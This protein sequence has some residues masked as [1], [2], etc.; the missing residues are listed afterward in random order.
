MKQ[1]LIAL[2][3]CVNAGFGGW[4]DETLS[5]RAYRRHTKKLHWR[6]VMRVINAIF[7]WQEQHCMQA[8]QS[9]QKRRHLPPEYR[10][11][12]KEDLQ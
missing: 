2:D 3:Q 11:N 1:F 12:Q 9:E 4:A 5:A 6:V 7:F 10:D 8:F